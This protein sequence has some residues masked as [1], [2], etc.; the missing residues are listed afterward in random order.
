MIVKK[1][2]LTE[3]GGVIQHPKYG[4]LHDGNLTVELYDMLVAENPNLKNAMEVKEEEYE[5][6]QPKAP[7]QPK[8]NTD[9]KGQ[10]QPAP[11]KRGSKPSGKSGAD[12]SEG[13][14]NSQG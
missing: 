10:E 2:R 11:G 12:T 6:K 9:D 13:S 4:Q 14:E 7:T 5:V 1:V 3:P 8:S